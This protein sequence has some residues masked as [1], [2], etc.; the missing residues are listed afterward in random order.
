MRRR[1]VIKSIGTGAATVAMAAP[2][3]AQQPQINWR[4]ACVAPKTQD[5]FYSARK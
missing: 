1:E 2:A 5:I 4:I 3:V